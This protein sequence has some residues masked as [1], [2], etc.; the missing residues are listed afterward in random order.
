MKLRLFTRV[1][2]PLCLRVQSV[3]TR[4]TIIRSALLLM[5][6]DAKPHRMI[7]NP[8]RHRHLAEIPVAHRAIHFRADMRRVIEAHVRLFPESVNPLPRHVF[9]AL[10]M[11]PQR[12]DAGIRRIPDI[13]MT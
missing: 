13:L 8:L 6:I 7:H 12:L 4:Q 11:V 2:V 3:V 1:F 10:R 5:A 9:I